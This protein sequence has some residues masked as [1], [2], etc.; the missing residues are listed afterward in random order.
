M[1][2]SMSVGLVLAYASTGLGLTHPLTGTIV[3]EVVNS[4]DPE[5]GFG[6]ANDGVHLYASGRADGNIRVLDPANLS[7][8]RTITTAA[9]GVSGLEYYNGILF[10]ADP[11]PN[12]ADGAPSRIYAVDAA[13]GATLYTFDAPDNSVHGL[14]MGPDGL[15]YGMDGYRN[16]GITG[17]RIYAFNPSSGSL[18][19][20]IEATAL[21]I[22]PNLMEWFGDLFLTDDLVNPPQMSFYR[23]VNNEVEPVYGL[24]VPGL[25]VLGRPYEIFRGSTLM[26]DSLY[27]WGQRGSDT[28][29]T[30]IKL[31]TIPEPGTAG[32]LLAGTAALLAR[33]LRQ[34]QCRI[35]TR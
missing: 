33:K 7:V 1:I 17:G 30:E 20:T 23:V 6:L 21:L 24:S 2:R 35:F 5:T 34:A 11:L 29:L 18:V 16:R 8:L 25:Q 26:G 15:L 13:T 19:N 4:F 10:G 3:R 27:V 32:L 9:T 14:S 22:G 28:V 31:S 12:D